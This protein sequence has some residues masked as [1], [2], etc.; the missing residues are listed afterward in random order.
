MSRESFWVLQARASSRPW[1]L[2]PAGCRGG[3]GYSAEKAGANRGGGG[4]PV[5]RVLT[6]CGW[7]TRHAYPPAHP[8][9]CAEPSALLRE[10]SRP[11]W[12][13]ALIDVAPWPCFSSSSPAPLTSDSLV[14]SQGQGSVPKGGPPWSCLGP[15]TPP[16]SPIHNTQ[17][18]TSCPPPPQQ[19]HPSTPHAATQHLPTPPHPAQSTQPHP[20]P[21]RPL[22]HAGPTALTQPHMSHHPFQPLLPLP[23]VVNPH[24][25]SRGGGLTIATAPARQPSTLPSWPPPGAAVLRIGPA[26]GG[27]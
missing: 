15:P 17:T 16:P 26:G 22:A 8:P 24:G 9:P 13:R 21:R 27:G 25:A 11:L 7:A 12:S 2:R 6:H 10:D 20:P 18:Q 3:R 19:R 1:P 23:S 14:S 4:P 5:G